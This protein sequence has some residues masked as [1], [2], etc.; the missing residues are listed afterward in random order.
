MSCVGLTNVQADILRGNH[1]P[2]S[3]RAE[4]GTIMDLD[5]D[6]DILMAV[7]DDGDAEWKDEDTEVYLGALRDTAQSPY[8]LSFFQLFARM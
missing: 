7:E 5:N 1:M 2:L 4:D 8:V 3:F 6:P